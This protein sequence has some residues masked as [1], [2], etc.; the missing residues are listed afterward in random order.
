[1]RRPPIEY[2]TLD[3]ANLRRRERGN[4]HVYNTRTGYLLSPYA[5]YVCLLAGAS[6]LCFRWDNRGILGA[7][8][9][10]SVPPRRRC[11]T[12]FV[13]AVGEPRILRSTLVA[14]CFPPW[15]SRFSDDSFGLV[16]VFLV[17]FGLFSEWG[18]E[19]W[20]RILAGLKRV[21]SSEGDLVWAGLDESIGDN[22][23]F[24]WFLEEIE[25]WNGI[26]SFVIF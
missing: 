14:I 1:M 2:S 24:D 6:S 21:P 4:A 13:K 11:K 20:N 3:P 25:K 7:R 18:G 23:K 5:E 10:T 12:N 9:F 8:W 26:R 17:I 22:F 16:E 19:W 15:N